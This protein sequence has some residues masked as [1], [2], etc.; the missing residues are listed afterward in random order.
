MHKN[1]LSEKIISDKFLRK[2]GRE[3]EKKLDGNEMDNTMYKNSI[4]R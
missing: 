1:T 3:S 4:S 2:A